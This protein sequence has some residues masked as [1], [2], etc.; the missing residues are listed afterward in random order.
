MSGEKRTKK[1]ALLRQD[2]LHID[3]NVLSPKSDE[4]TSDF[5][6]FGF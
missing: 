5:L 2:L 4:S 6:D 3:Y 1:T